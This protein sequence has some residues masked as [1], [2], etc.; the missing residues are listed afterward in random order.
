[1]LH[2][3]SHRTAIC[4]AC[5]NCNLGYHVLSPMYAKAKRTHLQLTVCLHSK[6]SQHRMIEVSLCAVCLVYY[7]NLL[8]R[9]FHYLKWC[10]CRCPVWSG[11]TNGIIM[12]YLLHRTPAT[13][14]RLTPWMSWPSCRDGPGSTC[15]LTGENLRHFLHSNV[16]SRV[17]GVLVFFLGRCELFRSASAAKH[18]YTTNS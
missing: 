14:H 6:A 1:M 15:F 10:Q 9:R 12:Q 3:H 18:T 7:H 2:M 8:I 13:V 17:H 4:V 16:V 5:H 11:Y